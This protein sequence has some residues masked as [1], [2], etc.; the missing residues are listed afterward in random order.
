MPK[1]EKSLTQKSEAP[2][3]SDYPNKG[4][5][6]DMGPDPRMGGYKASLDSYPHTMPHLSTI[7]K[8]RTSIAVN[9]ALGRGLFAAKLR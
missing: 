6:G 5:L 1:C 3:G 9:I 4:K 7:V 2:T 8:T